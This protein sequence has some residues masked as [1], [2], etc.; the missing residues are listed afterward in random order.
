MTQAPP[1]ERTPARP[2]P[3]PRSGSFL[4]VFVAGILIYAI[5][6][7]ALG[8]SGWLWGAV[9]GLA[10]ALVL[11]R[12]GL[13]SFPVD[14]AAL[15]VTGGVGTAITAWALDGRGSP[16]VFTDAARGG[17]GWLVVGIGL[18]WVVWKA[19]PERLRPGVIAVVGLSWGIA[20]TFAIQWGTAIGYLE[21]LRRAAI[22]AGELQELG[23][24]FYVWTGVLTALVGLGIAVSLLVGTTTIAAVTGTAAVSIFAWNQIGFSV[25]ELFTEIGN[26]GQLAAQF[27]PPDW[28]WPPVLGAQPRVAIFE[29]M[30]ETLQI[31]VLGATIGCILAIPLA[32]LASRPTAPN[33]A[34]F[35]GAKAFLSVIRTIP[36]LF[37]AALFVAAVGIGPFAGMLAML[38]FS[39]VIMGKLFSE[40]VDAIDLGPLEAADA[41]GARHW[42]KIQ[43]GAFPQ[44]LP[45]YVAYALYIFELNIRASV[46][47]GIVGAGGIG[48][49]LD[50]RRT[51]FQWDQ[52]MAIVIVIFVAVIL[53]EIVSITVRRRLV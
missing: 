53:I 27:W 52:V 51:L 48:R 12:S 24:S 26:I 46:V 4:P 35:V 28:E 10:T 20:G 2:A 44:V 7:W 21:P 42:Q 11:Q 17:L 18:G 32:F 9:A 40:T 33:R 45:N 41:A 34:T 30:V 39:L 6:G 49:L 22:R 23:T 38:V 8:D 13:A 1:A 36:D 15:A 50:E 43:Y 47:I 19:R 3:P 16:L 25:S 5:S 29:P 31:A 14:Y 37:W